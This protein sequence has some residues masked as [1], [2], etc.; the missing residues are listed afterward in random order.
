MTAPELSDAQ[1]RLLAAVA[2]R[3][4]A[5]QVREL[6]LF[7]PIRQGGVETG[8]AVIAAGEPEA[9]DAS[10]GGAAASGM[11]AASEPPAADEGSDADV[12]AA[13]VCAPEDADV[14]RAALLAAEAAVAAEDAGTD[15]EDPTGDIRDRVPGIGGP[16]AEG[17]GAEEPAIAE[18]ATPAGP[19]NGAL[20]PPGPAAHVPDAAACDP[21]EAAAG[22]PPPTVDTVDTV[23]SVVGDDTGP[24]LAAAPA[25]VV[26]AEAAAER[27]A[28]SVAVESGDDDEAT[29]PPADAEAGDEPATGLPP[30]Y[31]VYTARY[32]LQLKGP[33]RGKWAMDLVAEADAPLLTVDAVVRGV[34]RRAGDLAEVER[35]TGPD[36]ARL[37]GEGR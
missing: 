28:G 24:P 11:E 36:L 21:T 34:Q 9:P 8:L 19:T 31:T 16:G 20:A 2:E 27:A 14:M 3:L 32:R 37:L 29:A 15:G 7:A 6:Y 10:S 35:L 17:A 26:R 1:R 13:P 4:P 25:V 30:R 33:D 23:D 18:P 5:G 22:A 12:A